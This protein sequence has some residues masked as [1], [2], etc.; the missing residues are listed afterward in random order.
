MKTSLARFDSA[1]IKGLGRLEV[2]FARAAIFI[3]YFWFGVLKL[4]EI[5]RAHV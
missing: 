4:I 1:F 2:P 5:G 3:V